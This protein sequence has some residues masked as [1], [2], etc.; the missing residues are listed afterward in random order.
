MAPRVKA[1]AA[2]PTDLRLIPRTP[3]P[4]EGTD[5]YIVLTGYMAPSQINK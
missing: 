1:P 5:S 2:K 3:P 4:Q